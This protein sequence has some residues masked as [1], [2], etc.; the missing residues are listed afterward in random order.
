VTA[1][2]AA[3]HWRA[4]WSGLTWGRL[5]AADWPLLAAVVVAV[6]LGMAMLYS[7]T[8]RGGP[9]ARAWDDLV[10]KQAVFACLGLVVLVLVAA[11]DYRVLV[12]L[13]P[14]IYAFTLAA[15]FAIL[16]FGTILL[17]SQRWFNVGILVV[18]PSELTKVALIL[19]LAAFW[20]RFD[21]RQL[22]YVLLSL[23]VVGIPMVL[24]LEQPNLSTAI[25]L[26]CIWLGITFAAGIR[27]WHVGLLA[28]LTTPI[29]T[30]VFRAGLIQPYQLERITALLDPLA[31]PRGAGYQNIQT[32]L[33]V[34]N[35]GL[36]GTGFA[37]GLQSQG[38][39]LPL[40]YTDNIYALVAEELGFVGGVAV[41]AL[42]LFIIW[43]VLRAAGEAQDRAGALIVA[44]VA[45][46]L[47]AQ[48]TVNVGVV[49]QL[50]PV[51]GL[52]LPFLSYGGSSLLTLFAAIG[53]VQAV[54]MRRRPL[55]FR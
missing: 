12:A 14:W 2:T 31:D 39:W 25:L 43:R 33:A 20:E 30:F 53:L 48:V 50:L 23:V 7:A 16:V 24:V 51:T 44:G 22:R 18:Q 9:T 17:G 5:H 55:E 10:V 45:S 52:S 4:W 49:L 46:Y 3:R 27:P 13:A 28:L 36:T 19:S 11:T 26:G 37:S 47:L 38:G 54:L 41:L 8:L 35:G 40:V 1:G 34:G 42:L 32:L 6:L 15:L 29:V 21:V